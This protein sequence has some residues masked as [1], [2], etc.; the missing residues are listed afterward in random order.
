MTEHYNP[1][2]LEKLPKTF[3]RPEID[4]L[5]ESGYHLDDAKDTYVPLVFANSY[6][7]QVV[8]RL[9]VITYKEEA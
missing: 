4:L 5:K 3:Q 9:G 2:S 8:Q 1:W 6:T 7:T